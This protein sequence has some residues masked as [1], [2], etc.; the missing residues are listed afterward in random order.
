[1]Q[2]RRQALDDVYESD[3][4]EWIRKL[5]I[6]VDGKPFDFETHEYLRQ[7]YADNTRVCV[8]QKAAQMGYSIWAMLRVLHR[9][10]KLAPIKVGYFLPTGPK[11]A[12]FSQDRFDPMAK[13][14]PKLDAIY[15]VG[16]VRNILYKQ[17]GESSVYFTHTGGRATTESTPMDYLVFDEVRKMS[18]TVIATA[19]ERISHSPYKFIDYISTA[20]YPGDDIN[21]YFLRSKQ[22][23][24]FVHCPSCGHDFLPHE[25]WESLKCV[26]R[27]R[28][29]DGAMRWKLVCPRCNHWGVDPQAGAKWV[30]TRPDAEWSGY[31][32]S[33]LISRYITLDAIMEEWFGA[34]NRAEFYQSKLG[35]PYI[36]EDAILV[37]PQHIEQCID[38]TIPWGIQIALVGKRRAGMDTAV[39]VMGVDQQ[40]G[41]NIVVVDRVHANGIQ[42]KLHLEYV[43]DDDPWCR[44]HE[45]FEEYDIDAAVIDAEPN[46][47]EATR[48]AKAHKG[49]CWMSYYSSTGGKDVALWHDRV[50]PDAQ[51]TEAENRQPWHVTIDRVTGLEYS[52]TRWG[53]RLNRTPDP[54]TLTQ[55]MRPRDTLDPTQLDLSSGK[56]IEVAICRDIFFPHLQRLAKERIP[57]MTKSGIVVV[58]QSDH[59]FVHIGLDPHFAHAQLMADVAALRVRKL[60]GM[61]MSAGDIWSG[62]VTELKPNDDGDEKKEKPTKLDIPDGVPKMTMGGREI[63]L[64]AWQDLPPDGQPCRCPECGKLYRWGD[65]REK[66]YGSGMMR[67][68]LNC[69]TGT[70][71]G[72]NGAVVPIVEQRRNRYRRKDHLRAPED[73]PVDS[74]TL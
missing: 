41:C 48:F 13:N 71:E 59:R 43:Y 65:T 47:N 69:L 29:T 53:M 8:I 16:N 21:Y 60:A 40:Q 74:G 22:Y 42:D 33:Q 68:C 15:S 56:K 37:Q 73:A 39:T 38:T 34:E 12:E 4:V 67:A 45:I 51:K 17:Y 18:R 55:Q 2:Q 23:E 19:R 58:G 46:F 72:E 35:L 14:T 11:A 6:K 50:K 49:R 27:Q 20:G 5:A 25:D 61:R 54:T 64:L 9:T 36:D 70:A 10:L 28:D 7:T 52:L 32:I 31:H 3:L 30:A 62:K 1:M 24:W 26:D 66:N 63:A 57:K 44:T